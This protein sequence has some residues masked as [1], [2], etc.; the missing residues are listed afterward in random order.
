MGELGSLHEMMS[1]TS[2]ASFVPEG[3]EVVFDCRVFE[4]LA[5]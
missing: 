5:G 3:D 2:L 1:S 4:S